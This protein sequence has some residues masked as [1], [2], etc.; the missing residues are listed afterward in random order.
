MAKIWFHKAEPV[1]FTDGTVCMFGVGNGGGQQT[2]LK[3]RRICDCVKRLAR[4][5][6]SKLLLRSIQMS[7]KL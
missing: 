5:K 3:H 1:D 4:G 2:F 6:G 7:T